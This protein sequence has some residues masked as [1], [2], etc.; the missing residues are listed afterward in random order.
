[1][2]PGMPQDMNLL[3]KKFLAQDLW[4]PVAAALFDSTFAFVVSKP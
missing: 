4:L 1:M 3:F 2:W